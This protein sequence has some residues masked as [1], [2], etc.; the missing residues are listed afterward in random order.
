MNTFS[1]RSTLLVIAAAAIALSVT[2]ISASAATRGAAC[3]HASGTTLAQNKAYRIYTTTQVRS[4]KMETSTLRL[5]S[6]RLDSKKLKR[7]R[8]GTWKND[9]DAMVYANEAQI[10][11]RYALIDLNTTTGVTDTEWLMAINLKTG[12]RFV[13]DPPDDQGIGDKFIT[14]AGGVLWVYNPG[15]VTRTL[16]AT[17]STGDHVVA[18]GDFSESAAGGNTAYWTQS[19]A[20]HGFTFSGPAVK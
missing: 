13:I 12:K 8:F 15:A 18:T 10:A 7:F 6:C 17:D 11:G 4:A 2:P 3:R 19:A 14:T 16:H 20:T 1:V 9:L 5:Y